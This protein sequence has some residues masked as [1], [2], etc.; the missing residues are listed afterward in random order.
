MKIDTTLLSIPYAGSLSWYEDGLIWIQE[1]GNLY[2]ED[3]IVAVISKQTYKPFVE[4]ALQLADDI[5]EQKR[6]IVDDS[7]E[8]MKAIYKAASL[9]FDKVD[10]TDT[11]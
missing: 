8:I 4:I 10:R 6:P 9:C 1:D 11:R 7:F 3:E 2:K 5:Y